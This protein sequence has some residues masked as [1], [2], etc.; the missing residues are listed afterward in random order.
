MGSIKLLKPWV[1]CDS[2][3]ALVKEYNDSKLTKEHGATD[4]RFFAEKWSKVVLLRPNC[5]NIHWKNEYVD[6]ND[7]EEIYNI[8]YKFIKEFL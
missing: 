7:F 5:N 2:V 1:T 6:I 4:W 3:K 8:Y